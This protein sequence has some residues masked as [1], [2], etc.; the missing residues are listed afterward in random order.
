MLCTA[1]SLSLLLPTTAIVEQQNVTPP[2]VIS[3]TAI[4]Y[5][6]Q[7]AF[8][9][10]P[11]D[12]GVNLEFRLFSDMMAG[13]QVGQT[14]YADDVWLHDGQFT[15]ELDFGVDLASGAEYWI[16][17]TVDGMTIWPREST[18]PMPSPIAGPPTTGSGSMDPAQQGAEDEAGQ[19]NSPRT[20][21]LRTAT[22]RDTGSGSVAPGYSGFD[23][24]RG[25]VAGNPAPGSVDGADDPQSV[26]RDGGIGRAGSWVLNGTSI[27]YVGGNVGV[28][29]ANPLYPL[30]VQS[31]GTF[32]IFSYNT[33]AGGVVSGMEG[34][35]RSPAGR[36]I[37]GSAIA[38]NGSSSGVFGKSNGAAGRGG[39]FLAASESG[40]NYG[41][42]S[43]TNSPA[44]YAFYGMGPR[45]YLE[46]KL[47]IGK[48]TPTYELD[49][50]GTANV[51]Q[52]RLDGRLLDLAAGTS[53]TVGIGINSPTAKLDVRTTTGKALYA[54]TSDAEVVISALATD[55]AATGIYGYNSSTTGNTVG[56][57][58]RVA[59]SSQNA[60]AVY[61]V[62]A[63]ANAYA[64]YFFGDVRVAGTL[65]KDAN[66]FSIDHP[67]DPANKYLQHSVVESPDMMNI[68]NGNVITD[69]TGTAW[70]ELPEYFDALNMDFRYQLTV[71]GEF[72]QAIVGDE[73][74]NRRFSIR[75]DRPLVKVSWQVTG[76]RKDPWAMQHRVQVEVEKVGS[77]R[78][79][80]VHPELY[81]QPR[82]K[83]MDYRPGEPA[84]PG[85]AEAE[86][87]PN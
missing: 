56:L 20:P 9:G 17:T 58:G 84:L 49:V 29:L 8:A 25:G 66:L 33:A 73:I 87:H 51:S 48:P 39:Q 79:R 85:Q 70:V 61:G 45:N 67:L 83:A 60:I 6:G 41:V 12:A 59:S 80:Y 40:V 44:G 46:G 35:T 31:S 75:T 47:G 76:I 19:S 38:T 62:A 57:Y 18:S 42:Y 53:G 7:L 63:N 71:I 65:Y 36:G 72:A 28:G 50:D 4:I 78:G 21:I 1:M 69:E 26:D 68:Y 77:E 14:L 34:R 81:G 3:D 32:A 30:H 37:S 86:Q 43:Q 15:L 82:E 52:I 74:E 27:Y 23:R 2:V 13:E 54:S 5:R 16:E 11:V 24:G 10:A 64:G 22:P 55:D